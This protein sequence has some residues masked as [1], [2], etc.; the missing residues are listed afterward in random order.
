MSTDAQLSF[1][2][3]FPIPHRGAL[4]V[5]QVAAVLGRIGAPTKKHIHGK[6]NDDFVM[7]LIEE[8]R[9]LAIEN[10]F[11]GEA[12]KS[13]RITAS[14]LRV[15]I[16]QNMTARPED[17]RQTLE[18]AALNLT[19]AEMRKLSAF[20]LQSAENREHEEAEKQAFANRQK[21]NRR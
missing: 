19:P 6:A 10:Q 18:N 20:L 9:L 16:A 5:R 3:D 1:W 21:T 4:T 17:Y 2:F 14:S 13:Y 7:K 8:R 15:Y 12:R 11:A